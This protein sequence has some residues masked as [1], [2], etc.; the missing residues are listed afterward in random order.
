MP[1]RLLRIGGSQVESADVEP[2]MPNGIHIPIV[3]YGRVFSQLLAEIT[4]ANLASM[5]REI[6][7]NLRRRSKVRIITTAAD[8]PVINFSPALRALRDSIVVEI[9]DM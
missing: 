6:P 9:L 5:V 4:L 8:I 1:E 3:V 7:E 2:G